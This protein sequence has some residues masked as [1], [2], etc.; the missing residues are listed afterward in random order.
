MGARPLL[1][2]H[3]DELEIA[4]PAAVGAIL[5]I[6]EDYETGPFQVE[7]F[8]LDVDLVRQQDAKVAQGSVGVHL[9]LVEQGPVDP[10]SGQNGAEIVNDSLFELP[11]V[12]D[13][14]DGGFLN[15]LIRS[16][17]HPGSRHRSRVDARD[18]G[19]QVLGTVIAHN[20]DATHSASA[21]R[22]RPLKLY[23]TEG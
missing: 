4:D 1:P 18:Q 9:D 13:D 20:S 23:S 14:I 8:D 12:D 16:R 2:R 19:R 5:I 11:G 10:A 3:H 17:L 22:P 15:E 7:A 6:F 21:T